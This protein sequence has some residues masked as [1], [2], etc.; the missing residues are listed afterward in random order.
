MHTSLESTTHPSWQKKTR[1]INS[2]QP[3]SLH[4]RRSP[5][6]SSLTRMANH[7]ALAVQVQPLPRGHQK[8]KER[9][10]SKP[11]RRPQLRLDEQTAPRTSRPSVEALGPSC[12]QLQQHTRPLLPSHSNTTS[13][14]LCDCSQS[15]TH[16][17]FAP[18]TSRPTSRRKK[19]EPGAGMSLG[20]G[21]ARH[22][23]RSTE[24]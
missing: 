20:T 14:L 8:Q 18:K 15:C 13:H 2:R 23:T 10:P 3:Q 16:A 1:K 7:V 21:C 12:T 11:T 9:R 22:T 19:L 24:S 17:G 4:S 6:A 5:K